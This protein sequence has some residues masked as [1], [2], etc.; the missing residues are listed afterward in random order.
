[1]NDE[2]RAVRW[3]KYHLQRGGDYGTRFCVRIDGSDW[4]ATNNESN[5][6]LTSKFDE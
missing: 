2:H 3:L 6:H 4:A 1:M 5:E